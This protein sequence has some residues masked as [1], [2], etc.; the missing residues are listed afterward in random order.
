MVNGVLKNGGKLNPQAPEF[1]LGRNPSSSNGDVPPPHCHPHGFAV[2]LQAEHHTPPPHMERSAS[3]ST[4]KSTD[5]AIPIHPPR[6]SGPPS[7]RRDPSSP[8]LQARY[9]Q[10]NDTDDQDD[11]DSSS[12]SSLSSVYSLLPL[13]TLRRFHLIQFAFTFILLFLLPVL[14]LVIYKREFRFWPFALGIVSWLAGETLREVIV[15]LCTTEKVETIA[16]E[17]GE[18]EFV[19]R[20]LRVLPA[21]V[22]SVAQEVLRLGAIY[23][24]VALLPDPSPPSPDTESP[25]FDC[26]RSPRDPL[27]PLDTL[28]WSALYLSLGWAIA[29]ITWGSRG[30]WKQLECYEDVLGEDLEPERYLDDEQRVQ[31]L[32]GTRLLDRSTSTTGEVE[33]GYGT[34]ENET[35]FTTTTD[36]EDR[37]LDEFEAKM[38][39]VQRQEIEEQLGVPL[40]EIPIFVTFIWRLDSILLSLVFTLFLSLPFRTTSPSLVAFPLLPTFIFVALVHAILSAIW[41]IKVKTVGIPSVSYA[42]LVS[43]LG[44]T[45][46]AL[47]A[48]GV[49]R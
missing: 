22:H 18:V 6:D 48:W 10:R 28:F 42:S 15:D 17:D 5:T 7:P 14:L 34:Y 45:F 8:L 19:R 4:D 21:V 3:T 23:L 27:P 12:L 44:M 32:E 35:G 40:Y 2:N 26:H 30:F 25:S 39:E 24:V 46:A 1:T 29:E 37:E 20:K 41:V 38:R 13:R 33:G 9:R 43:L 31:M 16:R 47:G 36:R 11:N 49:L